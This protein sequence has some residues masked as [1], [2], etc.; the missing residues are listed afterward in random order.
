MASILNIVP[1][2]ALSRIS[3]LNLIA[4]WVVQG[5]IS[6]LHRSPFHG[7]SVEFAEYRQY[8]PGDDLRY[9]DWKA[10]AKSDRNYIRKFHSETN[11][12]M[13]IAVDCSKSMSFGTTGISKLQYAKAL[14]ASISYLMVSQNDAVG[15]AV[16]SDKILSYL[17]PKSSRR[18]L[19][20][21]ALMLSSAKPQATTNVSA[22]LN[23]VAHMLKRRG[24]VVLISDL[25]DE[26]ESVIHS[27]KQL[28]FLKN[29]VIVFHLFDPVELNFDYAGMTEFVELE[30]DKRMLVLPS[31]VRKEYQKA[32]RAYIEE[33]R[34]AC[35]GINV[36]YQV[37]DTSTPFDVALAT[38]LHKRSRLG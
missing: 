35:S 27:L 23:V 32:V 30:S 8:T 16:F 28:R 18:H 24:M 21:I 4:R 26:P 33:M 22:A 2:S 7:F 29:E 17:P 6:G 10:Y 31:L 9:F 19:N 1:P 25:Y 12:R 14:A 37:L 36:E 13:Y 38:Y 34:K 15:A 5:F 3:N 20:D 11:V